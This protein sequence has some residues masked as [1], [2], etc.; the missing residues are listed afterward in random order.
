[1]AKMLAKSTVAR[2]AF[3]DHTLSID[4]VT[5]SNKHFI[6]AR[7]PEINF[8]THTSHTRPIQICRRFIDSQGFAQHT[9]DTMKRTP[10][11]KMNWKLRKANPNWNHRRFFL[12]W[13]F[14]R[15]FKYPHW[16]SMHIKN[17]FQLEA[18]KIRLIHQLNGHMLKINSP[19]FISTLQPQSGKALAE[20]FH[21]WSPLGEFSN[22]QKLE[23]S[24]QQC[25]LL[26]GEE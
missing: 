25:C 26:L 15:P 23:R 13:E 17:L 14:R 19:K 7:L 22:K 12:R 3:I 18:S 5:T 21:H 8:D 1:M 24:G 16:I 11:K 10:V 6:Q 20:S 4:A 9:Y 2:T